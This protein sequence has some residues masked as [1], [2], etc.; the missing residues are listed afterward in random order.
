MMHIRR[1]DVGSAAFVG[2][3]LY[4]S[5][6]GLIG[7]IQ[8]LAYALIPDAL[9]TL[10][11]YYNPAGNDDPQQMPLAYAALNYLIGIVLAASGGAISSGVLSVIYNFI[12]RR[13]GGLKVTIE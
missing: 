7:L 12:A 8:L 11:V 10:P 6:F 4:G 5:L 9:L 3:L 13:F 2:G 1:I